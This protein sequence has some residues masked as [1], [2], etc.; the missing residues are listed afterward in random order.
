MTAPA[1]GERHR[2]RARWIIPVGSEPIEHGTIEVE[3]GRIT[4]LHNR[5]DK[6][7]T[8]LG[9]VALLPGLVNAHTHLEF[10]TLRKPITPV[11]P[12][13]DWIRAVRN[14][15]INRRTDTTA[16]IT[17]GLTESAAGG[18]TT[19]GE[20]ATAGWSAELFTSTTPRAV[21]FRELIGLR[22]NQIGEQL[23]IAGK[24]LAAANST[25]SSDDLH[26]G[27]SPHA[28]YSVHPE[29]FS[30]LVA[31]AA[32]FHAPLA[33][34]LAET[35]AEL[36]LLSHGSGKF[37]QMLK[38]FGVW[39]PN[40]IPRGSRPLDYLRQ[41]ASLDHALVIHGNYLAE[42]EIDFVCRYPNLT[43]V[44]CPRTHAAF[45]HSP[46]SWQRLMERGG[47]VAIGTDSRASNPDLSLWRELC[48]LRE[49]FPKVPPQRLLELGTIRGARTLGLEQTTGRLTVG[50]SADLIVVA[51]NTSGA[52]DIVAELL[53]R[54]NRVVA[55]MRS[56]RWITPSAD[57][58]V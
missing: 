39:E 32:E 31:V 25:T 53:H 49:Q 52:G 29:L 23:D 35:Q 30:R 9:N 18:T 45:E 44:Y 57:S 58:T 8:D 46:H 41:M 36:E 43:V 21:V 24:H 16:D 47:S 38:E 33:F 12:F 51:L 4:A 50:R 40:A 22:T 17:A 42:D 28:P 13:T 5:F 19:V 55:T 37:V 2:L 7:S 6:R 26:R 34:H 11:T 48:F 1:A 14:E 10:S 20:I 27:L 54:R 3:A 15:R 56:G